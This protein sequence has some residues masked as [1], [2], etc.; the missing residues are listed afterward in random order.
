MARQLLNI[1]DIHAP[2]ATV[3]LCIEGHAL[4]NSRDEAGNL[5]LLR[6]IRNGL[7]LPATL[8]VMDY[9]EFMDSIMQPLG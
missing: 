6:E 4:Q 3:S 8:Q 7:D 9:L 2:Q 1:A 5:A